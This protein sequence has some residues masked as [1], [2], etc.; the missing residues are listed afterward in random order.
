MFNYIDETKQFTNIIV[1]FNLM[2]HNHSHNHSHETNNFEKAIKIGILLNFIYICVEFTFGFISNSMA[3]ITDAGHN[4]SDVISLLLAWISMWMIRKNST[5]KFTYGYKKGSILIALINATLLMF[6]LGVISFEAIKR[7]YTVN[8][9]GGQTIIIVASIGIVINGFT[10]L[11]FMKGRKEDLNIKGVFLHMLTDTL[12]SLAVVISGVLI[13]IFDYKWIDSVISL[14]VVVVI[15]IGT[16]NLLKDTIKLSVDAVPSHIEFDKVYDYLKNL[17][18]VTDVHDLH[19]WAMSTSQNA[20]TV[21]LVVKENSGEGF[22]MGI[23]NDLKEKFSISHSTIQ[24]ENS[25]D[26]CLE[27]NC[28]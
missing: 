9:I 7:L 22:I 2:G 5:R 25:N 17:N 28:G 16:W 1:Q 11:L 8:E 26:Y 24:I 3:L 12:V 4:F 10:A 6:A 23:N 20:L 21:H 15:F 14:A 18:G 13:L 27:Q 19:I